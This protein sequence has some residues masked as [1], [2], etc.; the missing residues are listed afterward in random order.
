MTR[1]AAT[2]GNHP[3][4]ASRGGGGQ[5]NSR[6]EIIRMPSG[7]I[8]AVPPLEPIDLLQSRLNEARVVALFLN[9]F[10]WGGVALL[11]WALF[12]QSH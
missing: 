4:P 7:S 10:V 12:F 2:T 1:P 3:L 5:Y 8:V 11:V 6:A 9:L